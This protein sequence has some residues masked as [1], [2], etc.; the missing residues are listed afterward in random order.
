M[1]DPAPAR[2]KPR[3]AR[4]LVV[5]VL[6]VLLVPVGLAV[7]LFPL[8]TAQP[9]DAVEEIDPAEVTSLRVFVM[10]R[11][12]FDG[13]QDVGP[14]LAAAEDYPALLAPLRAAREVGPFADARGPWLA[15]YRVLLTSGR[16]GTIRVYWS[17]PSGR[18]RGDAAFAAMGGAAALA[19]AEEGGHVPPT[20]LRFQI[21]P[22]K[23][24]GGSAVELVR[25]AESGAARGTPAK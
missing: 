2:P 3:T 5:G 1:A 17:R 19:E 8:M 21:G 11:K 6:L 14:Y 12:E 18:W 13:G 25:A 20:A 22:R 24:E 10:N 7:F 9:F 16:R 23:Y 4:R 15:E